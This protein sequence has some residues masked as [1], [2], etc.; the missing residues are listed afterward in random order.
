MTDLAAY[1]SLFLAA[2]L[3]A[4]LI[5][6]QSETLLGGLLLLGQQPAVA[7][8]AVASFGNILGSVL[9]WLIGRGV[10]RFR[11]RK[12]FPASDAQLDSAQGY[13]QRF[14][15]WSLLLAWVPVI[16]DPLTLVAGIM[17]EPL[18]RFLILV[19]IGKAGRYLVL[20]AGLGA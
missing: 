1:S 9:N 5:P 4:T 3:A 7:L 10:E 15:Y 11:D 16:G 8:V 19:S 12:W 13:Y 17:R 20:A 2:L 18:W 6:A 14:G